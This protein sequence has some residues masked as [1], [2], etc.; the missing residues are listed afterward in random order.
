MTQLSKNLMCIVMRGGIELW[1]EDEFVGGLKSILLKSN[2]SKF[3]EIGSEVIN[4]ADIVG[5][6]EAETMSELTRRK[7]GEWKCD[8]GNYH[9]KNQDCAC[10]KFNEKGEQFIKGQGWVKNN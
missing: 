5:I 6:F 4:S 1:L 7:N 10:P 2:G 8:K 9:L 3:L